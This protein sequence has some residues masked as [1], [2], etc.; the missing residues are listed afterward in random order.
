MNQSTPT[1]AD[2][3]LQAKL[4][5]LYIDTG[6]SKDSPRILPRDF[7]RHAMAIINSEVRQVLDRLK[8]HSTSEIWFAI[9]AERKRY[10]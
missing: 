7:D 8:E 6:R 9:E 3:E 2:E 1:K 4:D 10:E 5:Q